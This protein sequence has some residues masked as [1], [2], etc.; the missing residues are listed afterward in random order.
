MDVL[1]RQLCGLDGTTDTFECRLAD[2]EIVALS[3]GD[4][5]LVVLGNLPD[6]L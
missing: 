2:R 3:P 5:H 6:D 4:M 1:G